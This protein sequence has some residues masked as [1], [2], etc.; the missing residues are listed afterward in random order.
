MLG[1]QP[2]QGQGQQMQASQANTLTSKDL[3]YLKDQ[4]SWL[5]GAVK[6]CNHYAG[7]CQDQEVKQLIQQVCQ[8]HQRQYDML[9]RHCQMAQTSAQK[10]GM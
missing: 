2:I 1:Q 5:L 7:E 8:T 9:L 6:K 4:M 10:Q 3:S